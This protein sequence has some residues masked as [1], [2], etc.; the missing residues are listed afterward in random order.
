MKILVACEESQAVTIA[1]RNRD[2]EA[3]S[4]DILPCSGGRPEWHIQDDVSRY[5]DTRWTAVIGFPPCTHL[6]GSGAKWFQQKRAS[7]EQD[8][9]VE[10]FLSIVNAN[11][12]HVAVENPVG[13]ISSVWRKP[14]QILNP[15]EFGHPEQKRTCLWL[16]GLPKLIPTK[17]VYR[18]MMELPVN[19]RERLHYLPPS[20]DRAKLRSKTFHGI[21][22]AMADQWGTYLLNLYGRV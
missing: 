9:A 21:A 12:E 6:A 2:I 17:N 4:C 10:F 16:D 18:E 22:D 3:Y 13:I 20:P 11:T 1:F 14:D 7:G 8:K 19:Q 15:Y 5:L